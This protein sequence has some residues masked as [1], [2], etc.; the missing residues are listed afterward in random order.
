MKTENPNTYLEKVA[1]YLF[2]KKESQETFLGGGRAWPTFSQ[3]IKGFENNRQIR[4]GDFGTYWKNGIGVNQKLGIS[5]AEGL[6]MMSGRF[7]AWKVKVVDLAKPMLPPQN[8]DIPESI[9]Y[10]IKFMTL[11]EFIYIKYLEHRQNTAPNFPF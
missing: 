3:A 9:G 7:Y 4:M 6:F 11:D 2:E 8:P 10:V 5:T 1:L